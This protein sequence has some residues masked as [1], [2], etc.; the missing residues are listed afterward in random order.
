MVGSGEPIER[1][2]AKKKKRE[3]A[4]A[5]TVARLIRMR[6]LRLSD[7]VQDETAKISDYRERSVVLQPK[8]RKVKRGLLAE[9]MDP[10]YSSGHSHELR[11]TIKRNKR[12][13]VRV[14]V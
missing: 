8:N 14:S 5:A 11:S 2:G 12:R 3:R 10:D 6:Q 1:T 13:N 7:D 4:L 9:I